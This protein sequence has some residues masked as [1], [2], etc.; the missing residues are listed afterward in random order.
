LEYYQNDTNVSRALTRRS[1]RT[2]PILVVRTFNRFAPLSTS[3]RSAIGS[4]G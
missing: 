1:T 2:L 3:S 4:A